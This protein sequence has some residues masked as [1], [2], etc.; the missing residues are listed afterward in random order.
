[1]SLLAVIRPDDWNLP[2]FLHI[3]GAMVLVGALVLAATSLASH[4]LRLGFRA[5]LYGAVPSWI[6]MRVSAQWIAS[7]EGFDDPDVDVPAWIDIGF[8]TSESS[9][10]LIVAG[11]VC[12]G[13]AARRARGGGLRTATLV[14]VGIVLVAYVVAIWAMSTKPT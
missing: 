2:L 3:L 6:A 5:L 7:K 11:T 13:I 10:L 12:A 4:N 14:L 8:I 1:M 9:F